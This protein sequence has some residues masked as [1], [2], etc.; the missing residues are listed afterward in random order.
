[1]A[2]WGKGT[3]AGQVLTWNGVRAVWS[4]S[5]AATATIE[6]FNVGAV[7]NQQARAGVVVNVGQATSNA[8]VATSNVGPLTRMACYLTNIP[9]TAN[10]GITLAIYSVTGVRLAS[11]GKIPIA[12]LV[13]GANVAN[14]AV[15]S[16]LGLVAGTA[17]YFYCA[18][19]IPGV[20]IAGIVPLAPVNTPRPIYFDTANPY[21]VDASGAPANITVNGAPQAIGLAAWVAAGT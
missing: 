2:F 3:A 12:S 15:G 20:A 5:P 21:A 4:A 6:N 9:V 11:T 10:T 7:T 13:L 18:T 16:G 19:D 17:Y 14:L 1:M 8:V